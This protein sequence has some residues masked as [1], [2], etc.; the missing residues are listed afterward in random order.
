MLKAQAK[1]QERYIDIQLS[2]DKGKVASLGRVTL[3][4][5]YVIT[6]ELHEES[7]T[8]ESHRMYIHCYFQV[9]VSGGSAL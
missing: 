9:V 3:S 5:R 6:L 2:H 7:R 8:V 1:E 4:Q